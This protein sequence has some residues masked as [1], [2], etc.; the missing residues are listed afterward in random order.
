MAASRECRCQES[1]TSSLSALAP[2]GKRSRSRLASSAAASLEANMFACSRCHS[3]LNNVILKA[4]FN[5]CSSSR[6]LATTQMPQLHIDRHE[7]E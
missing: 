4:M 5:P 3:V 7:N 1:A 2:A 6:T